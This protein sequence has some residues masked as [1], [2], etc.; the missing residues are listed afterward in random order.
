MRNQ[1]RLWGIAGV[2]SLCAVGCGSSDDSNGGDAGGCAQD[3][4][5]CSADGLAEE[6]CDNGA[7]K[8]KNTCPNGCENKACRESSPPEAD[9]CKDKAAGDSCNVDGTKTCQKAEG[10]DSLQCKDKP[11]D[12]TPEPEADPCKDKA[13]GDSCNV[14]G[15]KTCQKA[16][17]SD[18]LQCKDKPSDPTPEPEADPCKDKAAGDS[19]NVDGTKTCQKAEGS[20]SLQCKDKPS[21]P[22]PEPEA[23]P[24]KDKAAGDSCNVDGTKT[25]QKAEGSDSLQCKDKPSDPTPE[26][27]ADPCKDK[28]AGDSCN[29]D[30]TKTCQ[31]AE[32]SDSLQCKDKPSDPTPEPE[33]DP[34]K[35]KA[36]G[37]SCNVDGTKTCQMAEGSE[38]LQCKDKPSD[39]SPEADPC[40][41]KAAGDSCNADGTKTCQ[42]AE[43]SDLLQCKDKPSDPAS[44]A[45]PCTDGRS[46][47]SADAQSIETCANGVW[48]SAACE[49]SGQYATSCFVLDS[50]ASCEIPCANTANVGETMQV[51]AESNNEHQ[52][53][54]TVCANDA[55]GNAYIA[56]MQILPCHSSCA[57]GL[58]DHVNP[59]KD[60]PDS[61]DG[62]PTCI[63]LYDKGYS[64]SCEGGKLLYA[65]DSYACGEG[66]ESNTI[67]T[68]CVDSSVGSGKTCG[69]TKD[70]ECRGGFLC[71][72]PGWNPDFPNDGNYC[73]NPNET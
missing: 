50:G 31:K 40:K 8:V 35:D 12:P 51:C 36:A 21:D 32:G 3:A 69:C 27:E 18:S 66:D 59:C 64:G 56:S 19:C 58:C 65:A 62:A 23:D 7:W 67:G 44:E 73:Y 53:V 33:A 45:D 26:P 24:C 49:A 48:Q 61:P 11:S 25:C 17:G 6:V 72:L 47:C 38:S 52:S 34:C 39:P 29:V 16:E 14:D 4:A 28:A 13:A 70:S 68:G 57:N 5:R 60:Q 41:D 1:L 46:R 9:P 43:G 2:I 22:T 55:A 42:K 37:D 63:M 30:G 20:D 54:K 71:R 10:S 15:T